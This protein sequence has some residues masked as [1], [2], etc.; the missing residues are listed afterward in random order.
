MV[1]QEGTR[2]YQQFYNAVHKN[3]SKLH[4]S[5]ES[6]RVGRED[7]HGIPKR[8]EVKKKMPGSKTHIFDRERRSN[9]GLKNCL[10]VV[11]VQFQ[12]LLN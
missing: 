11:L 2:H 10:V 6:E 4:H 9:R 8:T 3:E 12:C 1:Q 5:N 7:R